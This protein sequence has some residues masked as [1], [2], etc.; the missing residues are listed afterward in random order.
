MREHRECQ[1]RKILVV[2]DDE[3]VR[4]VTRRILRM[5]GYDVTTAS[6][7]ALALQEIDKNVY[8]LI[9]TDLMMPV[10][11]GVELIRVL[12]DERK[13]HIPIVVMTGSGM[14]RV[15][16]LSFSGLSSVAKP[17][18]MEDLLAVVAMADNA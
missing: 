16:A 14:D 4:D 11:D 10:L 5:K 15:E 13:S 12:R 7:G 18:E 8:D 9:V 1:R 2:E 3:H 17:Y 6:N